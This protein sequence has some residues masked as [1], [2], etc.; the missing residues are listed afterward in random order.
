V[1]AKLKVLKYFRALKFLNTMSNSQ[2][3]RIDITMTPAQVTA[4]KTALQTMETNMPFLL[5]L[6]T[7]QRVA[8]PKINVVNK[9][10]VEDAMNEFSNNA[11]MLPSYLDVTKIKTDYTLYTQLDEIIFLVRRV[12]EKLEDTQ[13]LAGSEAYISSL[14][15][16]RL[17]EAAAGA[18]VPG[19]DSIYAQLKERFT[20]TPSTP[21]TPSTP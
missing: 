16:Y 12:L 19:A 15:V 18:G 2:E 7:E 17:F 6:T 10:F 5:G 14:V 11:A 1:I 20:N 8:I 4:V 21:S 13:M 3:N 9:A